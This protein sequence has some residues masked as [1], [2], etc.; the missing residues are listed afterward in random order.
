MA[1]TDAIAATSEAIRSLLERAAHDAAGLPAIAV[2]RPSR[3][4]SSTT[5]ATTGRSPQREK[6]ELCWAPLTTAEEY[7]VWQIA[8]TNQQPSAS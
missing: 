5:P 2:A 6:V 4:I 7:D 3:S 8:Q 1:G